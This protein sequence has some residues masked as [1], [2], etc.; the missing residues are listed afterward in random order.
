MDKITKD[1]FFFKL[2]QIVYYIIVKS[3]WANSIL[4]FVSDIADAM[5]I[6]VTIACSTSYTNA[7][8]VHVCLFV[9]KLL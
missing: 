6:Y 7:C 3:D 5:F 2:K 4:A 9:S 1:N 8:F